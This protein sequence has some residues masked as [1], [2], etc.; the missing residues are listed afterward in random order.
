MKANGI[1]SF[2]LTVTTVATVALFAPGSAHALASGGNG[3]VSLEVLKRCP[4]VGLPGLALCTALAVAA[5]PPA[6]G[7]TDIH[8]ALSYD[9]SQWLFR[10]DLSGFLCSFS[11]TGGCPAANPQLGTFEFSSL[12]EINFTPGLPLPNSSV[13]LVAAGGTVTLDYQLATPLNAQGDQNF[14][15]FYFDIVNPFLESSTI[16]F[17]NQ[18][19]NYTFTQG[20]T[21]CNTVMGTCGSLMP[22]TGFNITPVPEPATYALF[23]LGLMMTGW[24]VHARKRGKRGLA[25]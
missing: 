9:P 6:E 5:D 21:V 17:Y 25:S 4:K 22:I 11:A 14:F 7:I 3:K 13:S 12:P 2:L 10:P 20:N 1:R 16:S 18:P 8:V 23:G 19:G 24:S 15:S